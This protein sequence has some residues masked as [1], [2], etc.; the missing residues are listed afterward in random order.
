MKI[1]QFRKTDLQL[2]EL[3]KRESHKGDNGRVLVLGGSSL[4]HSA[5]LWAAELLAHFA[6]LV[7]YYSP[8]SGNQKLALELKRRFYNGIVVANKSNFR[9]YL[10]E[11]DVVLLGPGMMREGKEGKLTT[12]LTN[13]LLKSFPDKKIVID[14]G[15]LQKL[16]SN[17]I[18]RSFILTPHWQ[19][20][21]SLFP[22]ITLPRLTGLNKYPATYLLKKSGVDYVWSWERPEE[23]FSVSLGNE[24]LTKGGTGDLLAALTASFY[25]HNPAWLA[26]SAASIVLKSAADD[27]Y[28]QVGPFYTTTELLQQIPK[29]FWRLLKSKP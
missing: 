2:L 11:A 20:F 27:L 29:T 8:F 28:K 1:T 24:G 9:A 23:L 6:D 4:F 15:A 18:R 3:P 17:N 12:K 25:V 10:Q 19:E 16:D 7:F 13:S 5:S 14:A 21:Q 26:S 22:K